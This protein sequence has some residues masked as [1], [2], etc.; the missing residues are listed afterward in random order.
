MTGV[1]FPDSYQIHCGCDDSGH[2]TLFFYGDIMRGKNLIK[3]LR[4]IDLLAKPEGTTIEELGEH[5]EVDRRSVY[6]MIHVIEEMG[7]PLLDEEV[8]LE[9][10]KRWKL[11]E[12]YLKKLP[13]I[14]VPDIK[15]GFSEIIALYLLKG[16]GKLYR[17]TE[18][19]KTINAAFGKIGLFVPDRLFEQLDKIK[20]LFIPNTKFTKDY[21][22]KE[23]II[24]DL[25]ER[26]APEENLPD[27]IPCLQ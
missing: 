26:D 12:T 2:S 16:E 7:F 10:R 24:D 4:A 13:N 20:T 19:E 1:S 22:G 23:K 6:R 14:T 25:M 8:P 11:E 9:K 27:R 18:L 21:T 3:M 5:L 17:G 15:L